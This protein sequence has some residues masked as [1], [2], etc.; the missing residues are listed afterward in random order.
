[1]IHSA[2]LV[3]LRHTE[4]DL[5]TYIPE[6]I[7]NYPGPRDDI[8]VF[9]LSARLRDIPLT[10]C[11]DHYYGSV[12][13][14]LED[15]Q[16]LEHDRDILLSM[17]LEVTA[18]SSPV[19]PKQ[20]FQNYALEAPAQTKLG[21]DMVYMVNL[22]R[23]Q[24]RFNRMKYN[25]DMLGIDFHHVS[26]VDGRTLDQ[27]Y[28]DQHNIKMMPEFFEPYHGR[29]LTY[30]EIGCFMSHYNIWSEIVDSDLDIVVVR[31]Q[32]PFIAGQ[33]IVCGGRKGILGR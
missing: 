24:D 9:A 12:S 16:T 32:E 15:G 3:N 26:A 28:I 5:L 21:V 11:N 25:F 7:E 22:D 10:V 8:I 6:N 27:E 31:G 2:V 20:I 19:I 29:P 1:M 14:P 4:S 30:G 18:R 33:D 23:R 17:L 13:L